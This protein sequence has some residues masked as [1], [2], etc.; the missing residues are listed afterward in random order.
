MAIEG[1]MRRNHGTRRQYW[2]NFRPVL[3]YI[4]WFPKG[5]TLGYVVAA[6][7]KSSDQ[8]LF[9]DGLN[10]AVQGWDAAPFYVG[11]ALFT[12]A[13]TEVFIAVTWSLAVGFG[14]TVWRLRDGGAG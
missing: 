6:I 7:G 10:R 9:I 13:K 8:A 3:D 14:A 4:E 5:V 11:N 2:L 12:R 1:G